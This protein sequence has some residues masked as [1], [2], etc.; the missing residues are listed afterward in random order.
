[1]CASQSCIVTS[2]CEDPNEEFESLVRDAEAYEEEKATF[3]SFE[4]WYPV[5]LA[6][7]NVRNEFPGLPPISETLPPPPP[8]S[9]S[10][11]PPPSKPM[12]P[13]KRKKKLMPRGR[14]CNFCKMPLVVIGLCRKN[15]K[16]PYR[17]WPKRKYHKKC[18]K[19]IVD[20]L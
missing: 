7:A 12:K 19:V 2:P 3:T 4:E 5:Y 1:M 16:D 6:W 8:P 11:P 18:Y 10:T 14:T 13:P 9:P 20:N 15:G 17:D